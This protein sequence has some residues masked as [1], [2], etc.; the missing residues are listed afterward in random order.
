MPDDFIAEYDNPQLKKRDKDINTIGSTLN[1]LSVIFR[2]L[3]NIEQQQVT[4][5]DRIDY[6]IHITSDNNNKKT[7]KHLIK[8]EKQHKSC[9]HKTT[10]LLLVIFYI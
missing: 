6:N 7:K 5:L 4:I 1:E 8:D 9:F 10:L 2:D 3:K